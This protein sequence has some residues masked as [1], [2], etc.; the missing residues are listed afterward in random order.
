MKH[1]LETARA[2]RQTKIHLLCPQKTLGQ[3]IEEPANTNYQLQRGIIRRKAVAEPSANHAKPP[4]KGLKASL[5]LQ[6]RLR[7][8]THR[9]LVA[10]VDECLKFS[11]ELRD[12]IAQT[13]SGLN[14][15]LLLLKQAA[16]RKA[17]GLRIEIAST[18]RLVVKSATLVRRLARELDHHRSTLIELTVAV[19]CEKYGGKL[20]AV[21]H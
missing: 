15:R 17:N 7:Q 6:K 5:Q 2:V 20:S 11:H 18:Q 14:V 10:Q 4:S 8:L 21:G 9:I 3:P 13:L 12:K 19:F 16:R 1:N